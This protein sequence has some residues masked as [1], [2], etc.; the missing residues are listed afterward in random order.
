MFKHSL[1]DLL[2]SISPKDV[3]RLKAFI[4]S[5]Y[6]NH[7][8]KAASLLDELLKFYPD[9]ENENLTKNYLSRA[10]YNDKDFKDSTIRDLL[11][12][13]LKLT[14][15]FL[16]FE[17]YK[18]SEQDEY[19]YILK[20]LDIYQSY[21]LYRKYADLYEKK[22]LS[23]SKADNN[24]FYLL[25]RLERLNY[26]LVNSTSSVYKK[27][28]SQEM[29]DK[30]VMS[31]NLLITHILGILTGN[32]VNMTVVAKDSRLIV[33]N[34]SLL[35]FYNNFNFDKYF[36]EVKNTYKYSFALEL[37]I[38][39]LKSILHIKNDSY[40][41]KYKNLIFK[42]SHRLSNVE[43]S[44]H[45]A[46][47]NN[48]IVYKC[49][50][51]RKKYLPELFEAKKYFMEKGLDNVGN[52]IK[53]I[54]PHSYLDILFIAYDVKRFDWAGKFLKEYTAKLAPSARK[55]VLHLALAFNY[56][57]SGKPGLALSELNQYTHDAYSR[58][59]DEMYL[60]IMIFYDLKYFDAVVGLLK[61]LY[62]VVTNTYPAVRIKR[63]LGFIKIV[64][65]LTQYN[66][67]KSRLK[68]AEI[69][70]VYERTKL[71]VKDS[72]ISD[73]V[74]QLVKADKGEH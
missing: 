71:L 56:L 43:L 24:L 15:K 44:M 11:S 33:K 68:P 69:R 55:N 46:I 31:G 20:Q 49:Q 36:R 8:V 47:L 74:Q 17:Y 35:S 6:H 40:C 16:G 13:L 10:L 39:A 58:K 63:T 1:I 34:N 70:K 60:R 2:K 66:L 30:L 21:K 73:K 42:Y 59:Y 3:R 26:N 72:W 67:G 29:V 7:S 38:Y 9:F 41:K 4:N 64:K 61:N 53:Y 22:V 25:G 65:L 51:N 28:K 54:H 37:Y 32:L 5:P 14:V 57:Y 19:Y 23:K 62:S 45:H 52:K 12:L 48:C 50:Y 27:G 18:K